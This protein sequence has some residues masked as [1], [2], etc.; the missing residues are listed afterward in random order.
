MHRKLWI[1]ISV[2]LIASLALA[3]AAVLQEEE[4]PAEP[5]PVEGGCTCRGGCAR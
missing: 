1:L 2:L 3:P 5:A 4:A